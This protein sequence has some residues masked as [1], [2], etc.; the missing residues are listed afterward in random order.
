MHHVYG[1]VPR[2]PEEGV[3]FHPNIGVT[4]GWELAWG[5]LQ[6]QQILF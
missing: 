6:E 2:K 3:G 4:D 5:L 1:L